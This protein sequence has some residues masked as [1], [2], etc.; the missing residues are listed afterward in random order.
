[1]VLTS[2]RASAVLPHERASEQTWA[3]AVAQAGV[4]EKPARTRLTSALARRPARE[5]WGRRREHR[6]QVVGSRGW[7]RRA[8]V[9]LGQ[10]WAAAQ[11]GNLCPPVASASACALGLRFARQ[12]WGLLFRDRCQVVGSRVLQRRASHEPCG[13]IWA[14]AQAGNLCKPS[15]STTSVRDRTVVRKACVEVTVSGIDD[16]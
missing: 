10:A 13:Q 9:R 4:C 12:A 5:L 11:A 1:M 8:L 2:V 15:M 6:C 14:A 7:Q 3:W 16:A